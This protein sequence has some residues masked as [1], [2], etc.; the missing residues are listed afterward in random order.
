MVET[1]CSEDLFDAVGPREELPDDQNALQ[2][3]IEAEKLVCG[4]PAIGELYHKHVTGECCRDSC[5]APE[6]ISERS[7][8]PVLEL[9]A[10]FQTA[11]GKFDAGLARER[12]QLPRPNGRDWLND[13]QADFALRPI[14]QLVALQNRVAIAQ[15][16]FTA[17]GQKCGDLLRAAEM[18]LHADG[19]HLSVLIA[20]AYHGIAIGEFQHL[21]AQPGVPT[22]VLED[23]IA[24]L[25]RDLQLSKA[26]IASERA[27]LHYALCELNRL[28]EHHDVRRL[29]DELMR[30]FYAR[31]PMPPFSE[32]DPVAPVDGRVERCRERLEFL[33]QNHPIPFDKRATA[34]QIVA[35]ARFAAAVAQKPWSSPTRTGIRGSWRK[36]MHWRRQRRKNWPLPLTIGMPYEFMGNDAAAVENQRELDGPARDWDV[37]FPRLRKCRKALRKVC[38]PIG[39]AL[40]DHLHASFDAHREVAFKCEMQRIAVRTQAAIRVFERH[41]GRA[42]ATLMELVDDRLIDELPRDPFGNR[43]LQ[44]SRERAILW[45]IGPDGRNDQGRIQ[46]ATSATRFDIVWR[47]RYESINLPAA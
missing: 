42:P 45:S 3:W 1:C 15:F 31:E 9:I 22:D 7:L 5:Q 30:E 24:L 36:L 23:L 12:L 13:S 16:D 40:V 19:P 47:L 17:A 20:A 21:L 29:V 38:N 8:Q 27:E 28:D 25:G 39:R 26:M 46:Q 43:P 11:I 35:N 18:V 37:S 32:G 44:Y 10:R 34:E 4:D 6:A 14:V 2:L 41:R 33:F